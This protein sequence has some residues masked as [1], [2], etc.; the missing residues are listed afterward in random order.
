VVMFLCVSMTAM[1]QQANGTITG[2][3]Q[4]VSGAVIPGVTVTL[5]SVGLIGGNQTSV[6]DER[7][8]YRFNRLVPSTYSV[9]GEL[10]GF[11][12]AVASGV[13]VNADVTVRADL[14]LEVGSVADTVT[15][16]GESPLVDTTSALTQAVLDRSTLD[17]L[18]SGHDVWS[19]AR[20]VPSVILSK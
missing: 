9:K 3:V 8:V 4:D 14:T 11:R 13:I 20:A 7:G 17:S 16:T 6:S 12:S 5:S 18:Q 19:I 10:P 1:A 2:T 15:V